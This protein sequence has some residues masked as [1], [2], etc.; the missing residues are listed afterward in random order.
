LGTT[1]HLHHKLSLDVSGTYEVLV[2]EVIGMDLIYRVGLAPL[3]GDLD[4]ELPF[5]GGGLG[6]LGIQKRVLILERKSF[7]ASGT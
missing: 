7:K 5:I 1:L 3:F 6:G 4:R 2:I